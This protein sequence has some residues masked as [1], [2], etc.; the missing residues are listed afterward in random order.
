MPERSEKSYECL[1]KYPDTTAVSFSIDA[2][3]D[4][5]HLLKEHSAVVSEQHVYTFQNSGNIPAPSRA[6]YKYVMETFGP[7]NDDCPTED[8]L[9]SFRSLLLGK[10]RFFPDHMVQYRKHVGSSSNPCNFGKFPL[11]GILKQQ[12]ADMLKA[13]KL[14]L[15]TE[16]QRAEKYRQLCDDIAVRNKYRKYIASRKVGD[17]IDLILFHKV[18]FRRKLSIIK[19]HIV[20]LKDQRV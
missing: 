5:Y 13:V 18:R 9:I 11:E 12:N 8:E 6:F 3:D 2:F 4:K 10:N 14:G 20:F 1:K 17:F 7:L 19:E 15:I 16:K